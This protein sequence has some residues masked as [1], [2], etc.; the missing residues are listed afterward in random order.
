M[1]K[2]EEQRLV[3]QL[4][5]HAAVE[6][7]GEGVLHRL[8]RRDVMPLHAD[9]CRRV[10]TC[11]PKPAA[12]SRHRTLSLTIMPGLP[13]CAISSVNSRTTLRPEI[14]DSG[15]AARHSLVT[16][17]TTLSTRNRLPDAS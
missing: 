5:A 12:A 17:S 4:V 3:E 9:R 6:A 10:E 14:E 7:L 11:W 8:A 2:S 13:R 15:T 16:S 1:G